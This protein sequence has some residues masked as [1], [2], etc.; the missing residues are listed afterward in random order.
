MESWI[1]G[2]LFT[3]IAAFGSTTG[4]ILQKIAHRVEQDNE[5]NG[6]PQ[7]KWNGI[8]CNKYFIFGF[9]FLGVIPIPFEF[10]ALMYAG[11][12]LILPTGT[13]CT[14]VFGQMLAPAVL[15]EKLTK[16][17]FLATCFISA[18]VVISVAFGTHETPH[19]SAEK[20]MSLF[21]EIPFI[22]SL[23]I[24]CVFTA[25]GLIIFHNENLQAKVPVACRI[26]MLAFIPSAIGAIQITCFKVLSEL[27]K[28]TFTGEK[29]TTSN[30]ING[31]VVQSTSYKTT[32]EFL[33]PSLYLY[34][35]LVVTLAIQQLAYLNRGLAR[36]NAVKFL[37]TYNTLLL[38]VGVV[39]GAIF[40]Q[41]YTKFHPVFF[42]I[43][44]CLEIAGILALSWKQ[45]EE[46]LE[47]ENNQEAGRAN[48]TAHTKGGN[49][50]A[51]EI[52]GDK[53]I[54]LKP[55]SNPINN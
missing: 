54:E 21:A 14:V 50:G 12:S 36:Y 1:Y 10:L 49:E 16:L 2:I 11:Q 38:M 41:E 4:L 46:A 37:P 29:T 7:T 32:N 3:L 20:L 48:E 19:Y 52:G 47:N 30:N 18:G 26:P 43:G 53:R 9:I 24:T 35:F 45:A 27:T 31:T 39:N 8:P 6:I 25:I 17:D 13:G 34:L 40:F 55:M 22:A 42:P 23:T 15:G 5:K 28:N 44:C 51:K 33:K